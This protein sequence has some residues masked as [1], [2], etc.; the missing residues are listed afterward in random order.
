MATQAL[1]SSSSLTSSVQA[2]RQIVGGRTT[3]FPTGSSRRTSFVVK[4]SATPP[5]KVC[6]M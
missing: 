6:I 4:A 3:Q 5:V 1:V 2:A